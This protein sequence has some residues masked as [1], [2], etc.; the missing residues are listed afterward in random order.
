MSLVNAYHPD[1]NFNKTEKRLLNKSGPFNKFSF[2]QVSL[3]LAAPSKTT[4]IFPGLLILVTSWCGIYV[5]NDDRVSY[6]G[7]GSYDACP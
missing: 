2:K 1:R 6:C 7:S 5:T 4:L 3:T